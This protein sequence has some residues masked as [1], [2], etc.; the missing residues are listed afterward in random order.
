MDEYG[1]WPECETCTRTFRSQGACNQH[2]NST[3]HWAPRYECQT[4]DN[5]YLSQGACNQ[6]MNVAR[7]WA[8][9]IECE[10]CT[11][12]FHTQLAADQHMNAVGHWK[13]QFP[14]DQCDRKFFS[15]Q[16]ADQHMR[17]MAH[18]N[19]Y[20][21]PC[22]RVFNNEN[23]LRMHM[24]SK[25]HRGSTIACPFCKVHYTTAS[26]LCHHLETGSCS[27]APRLNRETI[28]KMIRARD[29]NGVITN[30]Q[31]GWHD[32]ANATY[33]ATSHAWNGSH[34]ECYLCHKCFNSDRGLN[35]HLN[36][37]THKQKVYHCPN[38]IK[39]GKEFV[40]L[41]SLFG[42]LESE[43]CAFMRFENVQRQVG[44]VLSSNRMLTFG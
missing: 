4:C 30:K 2:M 42:H 14:C 29:Q 1:H 10:T 9:T 27:N 21:Q 16:Q 36:S 38:R 19:N 32:E 43:S 33:S 35:Q 44:N 26:G 24:N 40:A 39:C 20:C 17:A 3:N 31:I 12:K 7:H 8:P 5:E 15:H 11:R 34:W 23:N 41:A 37:P 25:T 13:P 18:Y 22:G 28:F 6:H